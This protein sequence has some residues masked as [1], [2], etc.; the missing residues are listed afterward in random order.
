MTLQKCEALQSSIETIELAVA[1]SIFR[2]TLDLSFLSN[3][4]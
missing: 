2:E 3:L 4:C 1:N